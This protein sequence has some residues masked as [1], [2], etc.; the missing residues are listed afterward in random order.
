MGGATVARLATAPFE[1]VGRF[2]D[3][4]NATL[5]ARMLDRHDA[6]LPDGIRLE[7]LDPEDLAV[8]KPQR[9]E[10]PLWDFPGG[11]LHR[12]EVAAHAISSAA[13]WELVPPT[14]L[15]T[16][17][18]FGPGALQRYVAHDPTAHYFHLRDAAAPR[19]VEQL[20]TM[21]VFD[22]VINNADRKAGHVLLGTNQEAGRIWC[23][24]HGVSFHAEPKLRTVAWDFAHDPVPSRLRDDLRRLQGWLDAAG[25]E[26]LTR[27][28]DVDEITALRS[29]VQTAV[30]LDAFPEPEGPRPFP[31]PLV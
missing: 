31:W 15:R 16:D 25:D 26:V 7:E 22:L 4:S 3:A 20:R 13:G 9:G 27:L 24:D 2:A 30:T 18:P 6:P 5:L 12:R 14:V 29:R 28:L 19:V 8:Y 10:A 23:I 11:T 17:G 21:V 1:V